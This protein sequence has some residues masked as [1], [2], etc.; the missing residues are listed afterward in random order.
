LIQINK[1][2]EKGQWR[3]VLRRDMHNTKIGLSFMPE[4]KY[5]FGIALNGVSN[6]GHGHWV[7]LPL[8]L[9]FGGDET[10]FTAE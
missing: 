6:S 2:Y 1:S 10:D 7:S 9:S 3:V 4:N 5:T 8:T